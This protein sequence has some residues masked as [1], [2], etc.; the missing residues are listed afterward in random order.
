MFNMPATIQILDYWTKVALTAI[1]KEPVRE[2]IANDI[3]T[4]IT[5]DWELLDPTPFTEP[6]WG[7]VLN[8]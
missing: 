4:G 6:I 8:R 3:E 2:C 5:D 7:T 1:W